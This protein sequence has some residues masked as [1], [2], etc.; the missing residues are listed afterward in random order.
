MLDLSNYPKFQRDIEGHVQALELMVVIGW[1]FDNTS[2]PNANNFY[3]NL[4]GGPKID[5][6]FIS[7]VEQ[8]WGTWDFSTASEWQKI[9]DA[10]ETVFDDA[11]QYNND[12]DI[13]IFWYDFGLK[14]PHFEERV[15]IFQRKYSINYFTFKLS[16]AD[17]N[18]ISGGMNLWGIKNVGM[19]NN[20]ST[21]FINGRI[22]GKFKFTDVLKIRAITNE[23]V[24]I[25]VDVGV[26][27]FL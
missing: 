14:I 25:F 27:K 26:P 5:S 20:V 17:N 4:F 12:D 15:D 22:K 8:T 6:I 16:N 19:I 23:N 21:P 10:Y 13:P 3:T 11:P 24:V 1:D 2:G 9:K 7:Q 18:D